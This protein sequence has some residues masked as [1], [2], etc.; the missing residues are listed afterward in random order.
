[1]ARP[2]LVLWDIDGTLMRGGGVGQRAL[3]AAFREVF[4]VAAI[5]LGKIPFGGNTDPAIVADGLALLGHADE[6][7]HYDAVIAA[8]LRHLVAE[9]ALRAPFYR[10]PGVGAALDAL[11]AL[12][13]S[14]LAQGLGTGNVEAAAWLK[15]E[16]VGL[17]AHFGFGG[18]GSDAR[19]RGELLRIGRDRGAARLGLAAERC[20][21][22]VIGDT[23][24]DIT[25]ARAIGAE[26]IA[27]ATGGVS[28]ETLREAGPDRALTSLAGDEALSTLVAFTRAG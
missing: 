14:G 27:V 19:D 12:A 22:I 5:D 10:L 21:T 2:T 7:H 11:S 26:V 9:I 3:E 15:V 20:R 6:A 25:A 24:R 8:Y 17:R 28:L 18:F 1:M 16:A 23:V 13:D 4:T